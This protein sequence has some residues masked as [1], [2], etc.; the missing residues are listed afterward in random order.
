MIV[1]DAQDSTRVHRR[2]AA[3]PMAQSEAPVAAHLS[4][5]SR[6]GLLVLLV[7]RR[8]QSQSRCTAEST[9]TQKDARK[10]NLDCDCAPIM[11]QITG[12]RALP[13]FF[14]VADTR[15]SVTGIVTYPSTMRPD[16][17]TLPGRSRHPD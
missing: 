12:M 16:I 1:T 14:L 17:R 5:V 10:R 13:S 9:E 15:N 2:T 11:I 4:R 3:H 6:A 8:R 7:V